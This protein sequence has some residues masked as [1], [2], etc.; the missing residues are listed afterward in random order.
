MYYQLNLPL[1]AVFFNELAVLIFYKK[2]ELENHLSFLREE[3]KRIGLIP[4]MGALHQGHL[5]LLN[6]AKEYCD[7]RLCSIFVNPTQFNNAEDMEKYPRPIEKD[8][9]NLKEA[10]CD[11]LFMPEVDEMYAEGEEWHINLE[12]LDSILEGAFRP[13][14]FQGVTQIVKK[15][16]DIAKPDIACFGQ[17]DYQQ[18]LVIEKMVHLLKI[19]VELKLC[20]TVRETDGLAMSSRNIRLSDRGRNQA[21][22]IYKSLIYLKQHIRR[23]T[24]E[25]SKVKAIEMLESIPDLKLEY[26][27]ICDLD[28]LEPLTDYTTNESVIALIAV[29]IDGVRLIDNMI[30]EVEN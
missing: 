18:Y 29:W 12:G 4:T 23:E 15:L 11:L 13:G 30:I 3:G 10:G 24:I 22:I 27:E 7:I 2:K 20:P 9:N 14:H 16:F 26:V 8:I 5:T 28:S 6:Y 17:K 1:L 25:K 21:L 19:P